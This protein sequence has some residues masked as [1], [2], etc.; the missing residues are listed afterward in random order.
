[1]IGGEKSDAEVQFGLAAVL[2]I[3]F[4]HIIIDEEA[5]FVPTCPVVLSDLHRV[6]QDVLQSVCQAFS[7]RESFLKVLLDNME[8]RLCDPLFIRA[9]GGSFD[10]N[11]DVFVLKAV[12]CP[13]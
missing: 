5:A 3:A 13:R 7:G 4:P 1:L 6:E 8:Q 10:G 12:R 2:N 11:F 9:V